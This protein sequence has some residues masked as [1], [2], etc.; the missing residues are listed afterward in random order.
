MRRHLQ[1]AQLSARTAHEALRLGDTVSSSSRAYYAMFDAARASP[2]ALDPELAAAKTHATVI[3]RF[4]KHLIK[5]RGLDAKHARAL[6]TAFD[7]RQVADYDADP[8][9]PE[10]VAAALR[11]MDAFIVAECEMFPDIVE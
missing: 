8:P 11:E 10:M 3:R 6:R 7:V 1:Q 4:S 5:E 2:A 9:K